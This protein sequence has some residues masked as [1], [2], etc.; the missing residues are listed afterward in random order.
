MYSPE[1]LYIYH[2]QSL[3]EAFDFTRYTYNQPLV[4]CVYWNMHCL[5][6]ALTHLNPPSL[7]LRAAPTCTCTVQSC[8]H[9]LVWS[10]VKRALR[11]LNRTEVIVWERNGH[12]LG[13]RVVSIVGWPAPPT[14]CGCG[15]GCCWWWWWVEKRAG[16]WERRVQR[17]SMIQAVEA[18]RSSSSRRE[19]QR[20]WESSTTCSKKINKTNYHAENLEIVLGIR[21][22]SMLSSILYMHVFWHSYVM[23]FS[24]ITCIW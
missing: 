17:S 3:K 1:I 15:C 11:Q 9:L 6:S 12:S 19:S 24:T 4:I 7:L 16:L 2:T 20:I 21:P 13:T 22:N 8:S 18:E 10:R 14:N 23:D 5:N